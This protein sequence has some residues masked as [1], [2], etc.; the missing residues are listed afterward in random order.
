MSWGRF[1]SM[2]AA[3]TFLMFFLM[4]QLIYSLDHASF[5]M[6]RLVASLVMGCVMTIIMLGFMWSM[7]S[8]L[9]TKLAVLAVALVLGV[10]LLWI[11]RSQT[12][13]GDIAFMRSMIPHHS[14]AINNARK[15]ALSDPRVRK[16]ADEIIASQVR[17]IAE[18]KLLI[19][20]IQRN[21][22]RGDAVLP[23]R[24]AE[25]SADTMRNIQDAVK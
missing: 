7:Y 5:S 14:I 16:L 24:S 17:E 20:E 2:I 3:S 23:A 11:N 22:E 4:Y 18:M 10:S 19:D 6:N 15:A 13:I 21:G 12:L 25:L 9:G 1:T 8:G